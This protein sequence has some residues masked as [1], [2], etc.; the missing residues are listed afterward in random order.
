MGKSK[1]LENIVTIKIAFVKKL[2]TDCIQEMTMAVLHSCCAGR[3]RLGFCTR[4][5]IDAKI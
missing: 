4:G 3:R 5:K 1:Y 2:R